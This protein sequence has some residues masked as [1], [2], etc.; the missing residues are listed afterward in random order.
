M[1]ARHRHFN[2]RDAG[3]GLV[4]DARFISE[5]ANNTALG[6]WPDRTR[7][8]WDATQSG[9]ARPTYLSS[10]LNGNAAVSFSQQQMPV[11][12]SANGYFQNKSNGSIFCILKSTSTGGETNHWGFGFSTATNLAVTRLAIQPKRSTTQNYYVAARR[13]D[14]DAQVL[15]DSST[16]STNYSVVDCEADWTNGLL[17]LAV[18]GTSASGSFAASGNTSNAGSLGAGF[19][20]ST[21]ASSRLNGN[22]SFASAFNEAMT[23]ALRKRLR[24]SAA[25]SFKLSCN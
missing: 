18:G 8:A 23:A 24:H 3:A 15:L 6:T 25:Y 1:R 21:S 17:Y 20:G 4:F 2:A 13:L 22:V 11:S 14:A 5:I 10:D 12:S 19:G 7:N 9:V 16:D